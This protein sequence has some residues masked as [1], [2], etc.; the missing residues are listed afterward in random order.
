M[1]SRLCQSLVL[2][3]YSHTLDPE[4]DYILS[5]Q[6]NGWKILSLI[7]DTSNEEIEELWFSVA[8]NY[9]KQSEKQ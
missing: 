9:L 1:A 6:A 3:C 4:N 7:L 2:G 8:D 5:S